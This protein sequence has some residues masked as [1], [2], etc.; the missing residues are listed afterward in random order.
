[1]TFFKW[2]DSFNIGVAEIDRQ[3]REF[4]EYFNQLHGLNPTE[5]N[6]PIKDDVVAKLKSY[7]EMHFVYEENLLKIIGYTE[8]DSQIK[9]HKFFMSRVLELEDEQVTGNVEGLNNVL[10]FLK[11]WLLSHVLESDRKYAPFVEKVMAK[12][13]IR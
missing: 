6:A 9:E 7:A 12:F 1:M 4:F 11:D 3:H 5:K 10:D 2:K 8:M 13:N